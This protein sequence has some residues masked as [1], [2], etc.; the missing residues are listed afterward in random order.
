M[1]IFNSPKLKWFAQIVIVLVLV[2]LVFAP[3]YNTAQA[4]P[5]TIIIGVLVTATAVVVVDYFS[6]GFNIFFFCHGH[7]GGTDTTDPTT[8][9][10]EDPH[11]PGTLTPLTPSSHIPDGTQCYSTANAC[12]ARYDGIMH[13][14]ICTASTPPDSICCASAANACGMKNYAAPRST[15]G[16]GAGSFTCSGVVVNPPPNSMCPAPSI[17]D[18][19][20]YADP[21]RVREGNTTTLYWKDILNATI[22]SL[23]GGG[24]SL[25]NLGLA[26]N[27]QTNTIS[28]P[29]VYTLTCVNGL[30]GPQTSATVQ[31]NL[32]PAF[33]E[34]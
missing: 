3:A 27:K 16:H 15:G 14:G 8:V 4:D 13:N 19:N 5:I 26:G 17:S 25:P 2:S 18:K 7:G 21:P 23:A 11:N 33:Q 31:V 28:A 22:C 34:I 30:N 29:T 9:L 24:L 32:I 20:F 1:N 10:V 6:C 12:G